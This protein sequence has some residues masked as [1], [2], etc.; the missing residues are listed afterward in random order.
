MKGQLIAG[1]NTQTIRIS[2][3]Q[4]PGRKFGASASDEGHEEQKNKSTDQ[5]D[6][7]VER[8]T[9]TKDSD[10]KCSITEARPENGFD[11]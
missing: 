1:H 11:N 3:N 8:A 7:T 10:N 4:Q 6:P 9:H 5:P 2:F